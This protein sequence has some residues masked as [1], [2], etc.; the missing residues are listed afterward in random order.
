MEERSISVE[1][2]HKVAPPPVDKDR[3]KKKAK[4]GASS[5]DESSEMVTEDDEPQNPESDATPSHMDAETTS[6][7]IPTFK[8]MLTGH[9]A[10]E[11]EEDE[12][13]VLNGGDVAYSIIDGIPAVSFS[14]RVKDIL[15]R[16]MKHAVVIKL[17]GRRIRYE[18]LK[19]KL[20]HLWPSAGAYKLI[21]CAGDCYIVKFSNPQDYH[22][23][24]FGGPWVIFGHYLSVQP[25]T[26]DFSPLAHSIS[27]VIAWIRLPLLPVRYYQKQV[28]RAVG[29]ALGKVVRIDYNTEAGHRGRFA[30]LAVVVDLGL[31]LISKL[32]VD[33]QV[34]F[35]EYEN[36]PLICFHCGLYGHLDNNCPQ[37]RL[38]D[39]ADPLE[40]TAMEEPSPV[41]THV[42]EPFGAWMHAPSRARRPPKSSRGGPDTDPPSQKSSRGSNRFDVLGHPDLDAPEPSLTP[43]ITSPANPSPHHPANSPATNQPIPQ[44][45]KQPV[46]PNE[47]DQSQHK[48]PTN[49]PSSSRKHDKKKSKD[50]TTPDSLFASTAY[51]IN[52]L[53]PPQDLP[54][55]TSVTTPSPKFPT[56]S[57]PS[58]TKPKKTPNPLG[59]ENF[60]PKGPDKSPP[61]AGIK[62]GPTVKIKNLSHLGKDSN[63]SP[64]PDLVRTLAKELEQAQHAIPGSSLPPPG[65]DEGDT[66][67]TATH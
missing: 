43:P 20:S 26:R 65:D 15:D 56:S 22:T 13:V 47:P 6:P 67:A 36:L 28:I 25:W 8:E 3:L 58:P 42:D 1:L 66:A 63:A 40:P 24:L 18:T 7:T 12:E 32:N 9:G 34:I 21:D 33:G 38:D 39:M 17:L 60:H 16:S 49:P 61:E 57:G 62:V 37:K 50:H 19:S 35:I 44:T 31:P 2:S 55:H 52:Q 41:E 11:P 27:S 45:R 51:T 54:R 30:R 10:A 46:T 23:A 64:S 5:A 4:L 59:K 53:T 29:Q 14:N 48:L